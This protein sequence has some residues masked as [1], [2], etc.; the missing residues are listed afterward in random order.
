[1]DIAN[2]NVGD[3]MHSDTAD[4]MITVVQAHRIFADWDT[5]EAQWYSQEEI[6]EYGFTFTQR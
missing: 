6:N 5:G 4:A 1:M 3:R 2:I